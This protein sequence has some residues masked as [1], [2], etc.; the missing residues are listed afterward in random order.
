M[1]TNMKNSLSI[2]II[3]SVI[4]CLAI[5]GLSGFLTSGSLSSW[6]DQLTKPY[7][8]PPDWVFGPVWSLLYTLMGISAGIIWHQGLEQATVKKAL[9]VFGI[10]LLL[11]FSWSLIFFGLKMPAFA[12]IE[13]II[14]LGSIFYF[15][16]LFYKIN[17]IASWL[18]V[19]YILWVSFATILNGSIAWLN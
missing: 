9:N 4:I 5:G 19:P 12:L 14:L 11:N 2:K 3:I 6:Y 1:P 18:Q 17:P 15:A 8:N 13:I 10:H 7:F 16:G